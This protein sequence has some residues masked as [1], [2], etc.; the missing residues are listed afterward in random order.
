MIENDC[1]PTNVVC[2]SHSPEP[3]IFL[4]AR[5]KTAI[6]DWRELEAQDIEL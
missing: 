2:L 5:N 1:R 6:I 4:T 3:N